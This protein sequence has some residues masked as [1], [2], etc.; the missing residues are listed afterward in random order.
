ME[1]IAGDLRA[2][3]HT[4]SLTLPLTRSRLSRSSPGTEGAR[5]SSPRNGMSLRKTDP[6][7]PTVSF[8]VRQRA[9]QEHVSTVLL[10]T[11]RLAATDSE[12]SAV[13]S[14]AAVTERA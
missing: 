9:V 11:C 10:R 14:R 8:A 12:R 4:K 7:P 2:D 6:E 13:G 1:V 3:T 5:M